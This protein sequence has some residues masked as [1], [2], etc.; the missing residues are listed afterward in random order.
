MKVGTAGAT[1][2]PWNTEQPWSAH[3]E[4]SF[5]Y[6]K[7]SASHSVLHVVYLRTNLTVGDEFWISKS[8]LALF[9]F[10]AFLRFFASHPDSFDLT[11][12]LNSA[13]HQ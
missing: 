2:D 7:V 8:I 13:S 6:T 11:K 5:G 9:F 10:F 12:V 4:S 1:L 3:R